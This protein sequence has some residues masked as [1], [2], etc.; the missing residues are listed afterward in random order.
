V[1]A[2][3]N[4]SGVSILLELSELLLSESTHDVCFASL[5]GEE[6][7]CAGSRFRAE[8]MLASV[9]EYAT[10][11]PYVF[12]IDTVG[13]GAPSLTCFCTR[14]E[15]ARGYRNRLRS[16]AQTLHTTWMP[17]GGDTLSFI[18]LGFA[19]ASITC[20]DP[21]GV[22][23]LHTAHDTVQR[24]DFVGM[25]ALTRQIVAFIGAMRGDN[26]DG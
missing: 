20:E 5:G 23:Y 4:A 26:A 17:G 8:A 1:G 21:G 6:V 18:D 12:C 14:A 25:A 13:R 19:A 10:R 16:A 7:G 9:A 3:D 22:K 11:L 24:V 15:V 2:N